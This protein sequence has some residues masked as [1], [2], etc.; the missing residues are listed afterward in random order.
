MA[1]NYTVPA[2]FRTVQ[3]LELLS[4]APQGMSLAQLAKETRV[5]KSTM[6]R[7][8]HTLQEHSIV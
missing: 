2:V 1:L 8:L 6:F 7:I 3:V 4:T 5:P